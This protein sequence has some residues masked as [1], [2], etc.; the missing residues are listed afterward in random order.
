M[1]SKQRNS[2]K[3]YKLKMAHVL[4]DLVGGLLDELESGKTTIADERKNLDWYRELLEQ[5]K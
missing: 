4:A 2:E 3:K 1:N 5:V